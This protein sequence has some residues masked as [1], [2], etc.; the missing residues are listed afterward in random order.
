VFILIIVGY[1]SRLIE[2]EK[3]IKKSTHVRAFVRAVKADAKAIDPDYTHW[4][5]VDE[6]DYGG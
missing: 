2:K 3:S 6:S 5:R 4:S 1:V